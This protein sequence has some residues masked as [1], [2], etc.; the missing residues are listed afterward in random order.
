MKR[1]PY[2]NCRCTPEVFT[3][4]PGCSKSGL[5]DYSKISLTMTAPTYSYTTAS[6]SF[7]YNGGDA[8]AN[9]YNSDVTG[10]DGTHDLWKRPNSSAVGYGQKTG[11]SECQWLWNNPIAVPSLWLWPNFLNCNSPFF[12]LP[13]TAAEIR[14]GTP[15]VPVNA[16]D[17][18]DPWDRVLVTNPDTDCGNCFCA[19]CGSMFSNPR[20][21]YRCGN[22]VYY[23]AGSLYVIEG[24]APAGSPPIYTPSGTGYYYWIFEFKASSAESFSYNKN[25]SGGS[26]IVR[27]AGSSAGTFGIDFV[28][29]PDFGGHVV[30]GIALDSI[31]ESLITIQYA[32]EID[33]DTDFEGSPIVIP[34]DQVIDETNDLSYVM[35]SYPSSVTIELQT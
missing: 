28:T 35:D 24:G 23:S 16:I 33:C 17:S 4:I 32:K 14:D 2:C 5:F 6:D 22:I 1:P 31:H 11:S 8:V 30:G 13:Y 20:G 10:I 19:G 18:A 34:F 27:T 15:Y 26:P 29:K 9:V 7:T 25:I 12:P 3:C 21:H